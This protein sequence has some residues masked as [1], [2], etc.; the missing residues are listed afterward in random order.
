VVTVSELVQ[1]VNIA[2]GIQ[3]VSTCPKLDID[4]VNGITVNELVAAANNALRG[5]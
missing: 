1:G 4:G 2:L 3:D 5:C